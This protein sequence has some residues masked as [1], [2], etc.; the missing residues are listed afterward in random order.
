M[1]SLGRSTPLRQN[2]LTRITGVP[3]REIFAPQE[4]RA[5]LSPRRRSHQGSPSYKTISFS[6]C[7]STHN[8]VHNTLLERDLADPMAKRIG[9]QDMPAPIHGDTE[10]IG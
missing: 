5:F 7:P 9:H 2:A 8:N 4:S 10:W 3:R 6:A 1:P